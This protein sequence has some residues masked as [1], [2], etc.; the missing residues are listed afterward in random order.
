M[1]CGAARRVTSPVMMD[2][3]PH[4]ESSEAS[5][6]DLTEE[7]DTAPAEDAQ[8]E[9]HSEAEDQPEQE[10]Q[11]GTEGQAQADA[12]ADE[13]D[14]PEAAEEESDAAASDTP[15]AQ[16]EAAADALPSVDVLQAAMAE[17]RMA[18]DDTELPEAPPFQVEDLDKH[19]EA[20]VFTADAP[21]QPAD[22][23]DALN[24]AHGLELEPNVV[25]NH[26]EALCEKYAEAHFPFQV[27]ES[28]GGY[29]FMSKT[30]Y[31]E[32][33]SYFL[34]LKS[35]RRL[36]RAAMETL[37]IIAYRQ[38]VSKSEVENIRGVSCDYSIQKLLEKELI[39]IS[40]RADTPGKP[41]LY[42]TSVAFMDHFGINSVDDLPKLK[43]FEQAGQ[44]LGISPEALDPEQLSGEA[45]MPERAQ[46]TGDG[47]DVY[48]PESS[49]DLDPEAT[50]T[51][52]TEAVP[53]QTPDD[54]QASAE[55]RQEPGSEEGGQ[56]GLEAEATAQTE[57]EIEA[58]AQAGEHD[59]A[60]EAAGDEADDPEIDAEA[61]PEVDRAAD[62]T[63]DK[64]PHDGEDDEASSQKR[65]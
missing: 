34:N 56:E 17:V 58:E 40:G 16:E 22:V 1:R 61:D 20:L 63:A 32:S 33:I 36:S 4:S 37:A 64:A 57:A 38:P 45:P 10:D 14:E 53:Q 24:R 27:V 35:K 13:A 60:P 52:E 9:G 3:T 26:L 54:G 8:P 12:E 47:P 25:R 21:V 28:G 65:G 41:L 30:D 6:K 11:N 42:S 23:V 39:E 51:A 2:A 31:H 18:D 7:Q 5:V 49:A 19:V 46:N 43:E 55:V 44:E 59:A 48:G 50:A 62:E 15:S 29:R